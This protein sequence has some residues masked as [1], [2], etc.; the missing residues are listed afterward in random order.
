MEIASYELL[1][2]VA[3]RAGDVQTAKVARENREEEEV[4]A[5]NIAAMWD[6]VVD[7]SL[8]EEGVKAH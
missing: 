1:E 6:A 2:R 5:R 4:M 3:Q 7:R 8:E